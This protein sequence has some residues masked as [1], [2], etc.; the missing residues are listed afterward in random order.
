MRGRSIFVGILAMIGVIGSAALHL[1]T[2][3]LFS[4]GNRSTTPA[5]VCGLYLVPSTIPGAG[6]GVV[7]GIEFSVGANIESVPTLPVPIRTMDSTQLKNYGFGSGN[8][9]FALIIFGPGNIYNHRKLN[10]LSRYWASDDEVTIAH[11]LSTPHTESTQI[12]YRAKEKIKVGEEMYETY[13]EN[14]FVR[15]QNGPSNDVTEAEQVAK[16]M[17]VS[18]MQQ[19]GHCLTDVDIRPSSIPGAGAGLF[20][21]K[22]FQAGEVVTISPVLSLLRRV[23]DASADTSVLKNYCFAAEDSDHVMFP[24]N[25]GPIINHNST[26]EANVRIEWYDWSPAVEAL[27]AKYPSDSPTGKTNRNLRLQDKLN[28]TAKEL[29][30]APFAQLDIAYVAIRPIAPGEE[31]VLDYGAAWQTA[32]TEF[33]ARKAEYDATNRDPAFRAPTFREYM[34]V[35]KGLYPK[36]WTHQKDTT[37]RRFLMP[38]TIPGAGRGIIAGQSHYQDEDMEVVP[39]ISVPLY[40][41]K[42][43][44]LTNYVFGT[45]EEDFTAIIVGP[46]NIYNHR[47]PHTVGR[48]AA[49]DELAAVSDPT[50]AH[51]PY[52]SYIDLRYIALDNIETGEEMYETYGEHW[53]ERFK[54]KEGAEDKVTESPREAALMDVADMLQYGHCLSD[55]KIGESKIANAGS[56]LFAERDFAVGENVAIAPVLSLPKKVIDGT[57]KTTVLINYCFSHPNSEL[58]LLPLNYA[59]MINHNSTGAN[60][61]VEWYDWSPAVEALAAKYHA[62]V[63]SSVKNQNLR[64]SDKLQMTA[65]ELYTAPFAQLDMAYRATRPI[66]KGEEILVDYGPVWEAAWLKYASKYRSWEEAQRP[67]SESFQSEAPKKPM[68]RQYMALPEGMYSPG[69]L[70]KVAV[71]TDDGA[72]L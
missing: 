4:G 67:A 41:S 11:D 51:D 46:G 3:F 62:D 49:H 56:G 9:D 71:S 54:H 18:D 8:D 13:G 27:A 37:C 12:L 21:M 26:G 14:W 61:K 64:M 32:W 24:L 66:A 68:F 33:T 50:F 57:F 5:G 55:T 17:S 60:V 52:T 45:G 53:F 20:A 63:S 23:V 7:A 65:R 39:M 69:W 30:T 25:Y 2:P 38:S 47:A 43:S 70:K 58:V 34:S 59:P 42:N 6:R 15:F 22:T 16:V 72:E 36:H 48:F 35:P 31:I 1:E 29:F 10:T 28:M 19:H 40:A 44:Q